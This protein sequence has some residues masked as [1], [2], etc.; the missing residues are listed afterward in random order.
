MADHTTCYRDSNGT[1][2]APSGKCYAGSG[3]QGSWGRNSSVG[4]VLHSVLLDAALQ[5]RPCLQPSWRRDFSF[6]VNMGSKNIP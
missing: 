4:C 1:A 3:S 6:G 5:V 2:A